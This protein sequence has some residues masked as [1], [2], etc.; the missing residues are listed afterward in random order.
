V[1]LVYK[2]YVFTYARYRVDKRM[3]SSPN[4]QSNNDLET[5]HEPVGGAKQ[6]GK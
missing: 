6:S 2:R 3:I 5:S 4:A 1:H